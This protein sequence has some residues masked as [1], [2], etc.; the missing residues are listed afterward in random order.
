MQCEKAVHCGVHLPWKQK[1]AHR[2]VIREP[3]GSLPDHFH[4]GYFGD[5]KWPVEVLSRTAS[6]SVE[7]D[8]TDPL[9]DH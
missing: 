3:A 9:G 6:A 5:L 1:T 7:R 8:V 2:S 4:V